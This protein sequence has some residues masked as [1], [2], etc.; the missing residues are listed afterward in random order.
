LNG[1][2]L[3][4][5]LVNLG[6]TH[7]LLGTI[8]NSVG[9]PTNVLFH[10][11][12]ALALFEQHDRHREIAN[13]SCNIGDIHLRKAEH[14]LAQ[15]AFRRSLHLAERVGDVPLMS[16]IFCNLGELA[17]RTGD[18]AE[19][20]TLFR[21][22]ITFA[23]QINDQISVSLFNVG[24]TTVCQ[25]QGKLSKAQACV[26]RALTIGRSMR[27]APCVGSALV[28]LGNFRSAQALAAFDERDIDEKNSILHQKGWQGG[29]DTRVRL[30]GR[31]KMTL[32]RALALNEQEA[33]IK[34]EGQ[35]ALAHVLLLLGEL[36]TAQQYVNH[37][38]EQARQY[39]LIWTYTRG[40]RLLGSIMAAQG[41]HAQAEQQ[42]EQAIEVFRRSEMRLEYGRALQC[43]GVSLLQR[44]S[45]AKM[46]RQRG[47]GYLQE[48]SQI[49]SKC[50]AEL[51]FKQVEGI[52]AGH[53]PA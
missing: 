29:N 42:F 18:L 19:A 11:N 50:H 5:D 14:T 34:T 25:I 30:L 16:V 15:A 2:A 20:E 3:A 36:N 32:E 23:E 33:E 31:A 48:A 43:Y 1:I 52:L 37:T 22:S 46:S 28:A 17:V 38:L 6:R 41:K 35:L 12:T 49:F 47:W 7:A 21:R 4:G 45:A 8:A 24:L 26:L 13:V 51:D 27:N 44:K 53:T 39:E 10:L 40:L 9:R